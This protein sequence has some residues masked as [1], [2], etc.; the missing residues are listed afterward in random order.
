MVPDKLP[1]HARGQVRAR[2][3]GAPY[4][5]GQWVRV[6]D[7][8][9]P[10]TFEHVLPFQPRG[11]VEAGIRLLFVGRLGRVDYLN[12]DCGCA[13]QYPHAPMIGLV[14]RELDG[15][16]HTEEFWAEELR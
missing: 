10:E 5:V 11:Q 4:Q 13:Q 6:V 9:D 12:Y 1:E 16:T 14:F 2:V 8:I 3:D 15:S 7:I